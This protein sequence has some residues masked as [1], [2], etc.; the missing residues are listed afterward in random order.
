MEKFKYKKKLVLFDLD[1]VL[2]DTV[3][4]AYCVSMIA[5][6]KASGIS[7]VNLDSPH[8]REFHRFR[9][10]VGPAWNYYYLVSLINEKLDLQL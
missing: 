8:F 7:G 4:E 6:G 2:F 9:F 3:K 10:L 1:G 5:L